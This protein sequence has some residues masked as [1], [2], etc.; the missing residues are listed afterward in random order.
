[1]AS[2]VATNDVVASGVEGPVFEFGNEAVFVIKLP[3][4]IE[5]LT[6]ALFVFLAS[7]QGPVGVFLAAGDDSY[8]AIILP[9]FQ[10]EFTLIFIHNPISGEIE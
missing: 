8:H 10:I 6:E 4:D 1:M 2:F 5:G 3:F 7:F 9:C